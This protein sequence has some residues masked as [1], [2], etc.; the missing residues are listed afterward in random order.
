VLGLMFFAPPLADL[1]LSV[2]PAAEFSLMALALLVMG[3]VSGGR[4][5]RPSP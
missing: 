4:R 3:F 1:M 5:P 2:G